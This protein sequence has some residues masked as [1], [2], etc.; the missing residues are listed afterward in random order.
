MTNWKKQLGLVLVVASSLVSQAALADAIEKADRKDIPKLLDAAT[1][2]NSAYR[3]TLIGA[4]QDRV[5]IEYMTGVHAS[6]LFSNQ[7]KRI[8]YWASRSEITDE[9]LTKLKA[10]KEQQ[11]LRK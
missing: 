2:M 3:A 6:S 4:T 10:Y 9:Q 8:V 11:E 1:G 5:Y 7:P